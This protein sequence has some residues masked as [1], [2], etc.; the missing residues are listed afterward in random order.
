MRSKLAAAAAVI[1]A[2]LLA[3]AGLSAS[4]S[5][6]PVPA[7][8]SLHPIA[9]TRVVN[10]PGAT[11]TNAAPTI[12]VQVAG[13]GDIPADAT[14]VM[15]R[16]VLYNTPAASVVVWDGVLGAPG[17]PTVT[18]GLTTVDRPSGA[19]S[20]FFTALSAGK[21]S[22]HLLAGDLTHVLVEVTAYSEPNAPVPPAQQVLRGQQV[23]PTT[24]DGS[25][26]S[27]G[28]VITNVGGSIVGRATLL[29]TIGKV[30][31]GRY[32]VSALVTDFR[33][34]GSSDVT[35]DTIPTIVVVTGDQVEPDFSNVLATL[36]G[37]AIP[38]MLTA[39]GDIES[40]LNLS[41]SITVPADGDVSLLTFAYNTDRSGYGTAGGPGAGVFS[42]AL[43]SFTLESTS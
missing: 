1:L 12:A 27:A 26:D 19:S 15:G 42:S 4:S 39:T 11:L 16:V 35:P 36:Q 38:K 37:P 41:S 7:E 28:V 43:Q 13:V 6:A 8:S 34:P 24:V 21:L 33:E 40:G 14:A 9:L 30:T 5:A 25:P 22:V 20:A 31:A 3:V 2:A 17:D 29:S 18:G 32:D 10:T 23:P